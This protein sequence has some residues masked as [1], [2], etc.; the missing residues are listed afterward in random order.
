MPTTTRAVSGRTREELLQKIVQVVENEYLR[1][2]SSVSAEKYQALLEYQRQTQ[3]RSPRPKY[4]LPSLASKLRGPPVPRPLYLPLLYKFLVPSPDERILRRPRAQTWTLRH[5]EAVA[6]NLMESMT[7]VLDN[8]HVLSKMPM[9]P[10]KLVRLLQ[11]TNR[12]W[13]VILVFLI[14]KTVSQLL[15]VLRRE[16]KVKNELA[17]LG[18]SCHSPLLE[19]DSE[20]G[21]LQRYRNLLKD[22]RFNKMMLQLELVGNVL[23][24]AFNAIE[25]YRVS[26]PR[27][28]MS[29]MNVINIAMTVYRMNKA[30]EYVDEDISEDLL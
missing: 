22:L 13:V 17:I 19:L 18:L 30:D 7:S 23:D 14:R 8:L 24:L 15:N 6:L 16:R 26:V 20:N 25:L 12:V 2:N 28:L 1:G 21:V 11:H 9:F 3:E 29:T 27:W 5:V 10:R 4:L